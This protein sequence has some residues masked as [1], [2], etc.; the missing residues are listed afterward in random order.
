MKK[1]AVIIA[2][3]VVSG[4]AASGA[5]IAKDVRVD[6]YTKKDGT[7][8]EPHHRSSPNSSPYDNYSTKGNDNPYTGEKGTVSPD[9]Q[10]SN[11]YGGGNGSRKKNSW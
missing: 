1:I 9:S 11:P 7:Y 4:L 6:G 8:V 3:L 5:A 10:N 2:A